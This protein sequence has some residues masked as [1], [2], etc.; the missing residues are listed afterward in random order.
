MQ[1][2]PTIVAILIAVGA[3]S[4]AKDWQD[5]SLAC[6]VTAAYD[7]GRYW[8]EPEIGWSAEENDLTGLGL[9]AGVSARTSSGPLYAALQTDLVNL[10]Q[11]LSESAHFAVSAQSYAGWAFRRTDVEFGWLYTQATWPGY[12]GGATSTGLFGRVRVTNGDLAWSAAL[13]G[14]RRFGRYGPE[15]Q[16]LPVVEAG[17]RLW[18]LVYPHAAAG[19]YIGEQ[20]IGSGATQAQVFVSLGVSVMPG[21]WMSDVL[22]R[23]TS[24]KQVRF[25]EA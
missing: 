24:P 16:L 13:A 18:G 8:R 20:Y 1:G 12:L 22:A 4:A 15:S 3:A 9:T 11:L 19:L 25:I 2:T 21:A 10:N 5:P 6:H 17:Y 14:V 23:M 7:V